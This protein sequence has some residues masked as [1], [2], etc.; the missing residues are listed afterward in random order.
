MKTIRGTVRRSR[1]RLYHVE[2]G[3]ATY[4]L[5]FAARPGESFSREERRIIMDSCKFGHPERWI[6]HGAVVM[7]DHVHMLLTPVIVKSESGCAGVDTRAPNVDTRAPNVD[8]RAPSASGAVGWYS[9]SEIVKGAKSFTARRIN[10]L[11][12]RERGSIWLDE[13]YDRS[14]RDE[15]DFAVK[16]EY[17][18]SNPVKR[19]LAARPEE[20]DAL[21]ISENAEMRC[22]R[23]L[24]RKR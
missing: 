8:T 1:G 21:W 19:R 22:E 4:F 17:M 18:K 11:R 14:V 2:S 24:N 20:W 23:L 5:T 9:L 12:G 7:P 13:Y 10:R 16:I 3:G 6:L 15:E